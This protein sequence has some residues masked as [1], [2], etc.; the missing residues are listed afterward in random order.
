METHDLESWAEF[1]PLIHKIRDGYG[2]RKVDLPDGGPYDKKVGILFRGHSNSNWEL[3]TTLERETPDQFDILS[4]W[5]IADHCINEIESI[6]GKRWDIKTYPEIREEISAAQDS[7][8]VILPSLEYLER[9]P[10]IISD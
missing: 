8:R 3:N 5:I 4:Y 2:T 6:T 1:G 10:K 9:F 7:M